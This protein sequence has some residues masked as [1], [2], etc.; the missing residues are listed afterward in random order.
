[1]AYTSIV[2]ASINDT[3]ISEAAPTTNYVGSPLQV[4]NNVSSSVEEISLVNFNVSGETTTDLKLVRLYFYVVSGG[5]TNTSEFTAKRITSS[6]TG[7]S[8]TWNTQPTYT[9]S[10]S[11]SVS[12]D[13]SDG[14]WYYINVTDMVT[15]IIGGTNYGISLHDTS[16]NQ[17]VSTIITQEGFSNEPYL[18]FYYGV[19]EACQSTGAIYAGTQY[20]SDYGVASIHLVEISP[21]GAHNQLCNVTTPWGDVH[22]SEVL[23]YE[24]LETYSRSIT[25]GTEY[26]TLYCTFVVYSETAYAIYT[27]CWWTDDGNRYVKITGSDSALGNNWANA[28]LTMG[29]GFQNIPSG[30]DLYV[31][32]GFYTGETLSNLNP[33][34]TMSMYIQPSGHTESACE[35]WVMDE[36]AINNGSFETDSDWT[37][38]EVDSLGNYNGTR[39]T[40]WSDAGSYSYL[41]TLNGSCIAGECAGVWQPVTISHTYIGFELKWHTHATGKMGCRV[42]FGDTVVWSEIIGVNDKTQT[43]EIDMSAYDGITN[44]LRFEL[45][46]SIAITGGDYDT[47]WDSIVE[48][49]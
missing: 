10:E 34:Q 1:M 13:S 48:Y 36:S 15:T 28:W 42:R 8:V 2:G 45:Y 32:E 11:G 30:K 14:V 12:V 22:N 29:Y 44:K 4:R 35:V 46:V 7:G 3:Y 20:N 38:R 21:T 17:D 18:K 23:E 6:W 27:E 43:V 24:V 41:T 33:P 31:E 49:D 37:Y 16:P 40:A 9:S 39:S 5:D 19:D 26:Y 47:Y 25:G